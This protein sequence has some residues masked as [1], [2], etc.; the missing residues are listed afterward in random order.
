[1]RTDHFQT[2]WVGSRAAVRRWLQQFRLYYNRHRPH[3]SLDK[4]TSAEGI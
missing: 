4:N 1:M 2:L 3:Q